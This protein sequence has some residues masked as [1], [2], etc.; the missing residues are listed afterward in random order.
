[1]RG[2]L[3]HPLVT[4]VTGCRLWTVRE[5]AR[6]GGNGRTRHIRHSALSGFPGDHNP[7]GREQKYSTDQGADTARGCLFHKS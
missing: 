4:D 3:G 5:G 6:D 7:R 1:V 2:H